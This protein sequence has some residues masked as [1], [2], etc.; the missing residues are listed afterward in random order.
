MFV[1]FEGIDGSGKSTQAA[2]LAETL[3]AEGREV[4]AT[5]EPGGTPL[6]E[7]VRDIL[8]GDRHV[9]PWAEAAL[10]AAARA[11]LV[12]EVVRPA[13]VRG[14]FVVC[15]RYVDSSLVYQGVARGLGLDAVLELNL[16]ATGGLL[17]D[18]TFLLVLPLEEAVR[19]SS[20]RPDRIEREGPRFSRARRSCV[21]GAGGAVSR[22]DR[23]RRRAREPAKRSPS[24]SVESFARVPE[25]EEAKRLLRAALDDGPAHAYL[26]HG[27][28]GVGKRAAA[29]AFAGELLADRERGPRGSHPDL[30]VLE[31]VGDQIRI[32]AIRELHH[33]L[34]MRP[35]EAVSA[36]LP[37]RRRRSHERGRRRRAAQGSRGAARL[38][39]DRPA[40][41]RASAAARDDPLPLPAS[42]RSAG[43]RRGRSRRSSPSAARTSRRSSAPRSLGWRA[44]GWIASSG[45]STRTPPHAEQ[46]LI[47]LARSSIGTRRSSPSRR[48]E[49]CS[50][51]RGRRAPRPRRGT[52]P[53]RRGRRASWSSAPSAS[54]A[55]RSARRSSRRS[56]CSPAGTGICSLPAQ[57]HR[58]PCS[59]PTGPRSST[60][61]PDRWTFFRGAG[62]RGGARDPAELRAERHGR[63]RAR[64]SLPSSAARARPIRR[65]GGRRRRVT[66]RPWPRA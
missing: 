26:F 7:R 20:R 13:L 25:Q 45:C 44:G 63:S 48:R 52:P 57:G 58:G 38:R 17:P 28:R 36:G 32:D 24:E 16:A 40:R 64:G 9:A 6:G 14:A 62:G 23:G 21:P 1:S 55:A 53:R 30:Y 11:Q 5:R 29:I 39:G 42:C 19:R 35:F 59:T 50:T 43:S 65:R 46:T 34:H 33:D 41:R 60:R 12:E 3:A 51:P 2:L 66:M 8:L 15:D 22:A 31:P 56:T 10:F 37:G 54:R 27:P 61:T 18:R 4:V 47:E 49:R